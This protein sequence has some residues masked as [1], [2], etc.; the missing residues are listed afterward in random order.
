MATIRAVGNFSTVEEL[1]NQ[2]LSTI[3]RDCERADLM[4]SSYRE[5]SWKNSTRAARG[6][7]SFT[8]L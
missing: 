7:G 4:A 6:E 3:P 8:I 2:V 5:I 1:I